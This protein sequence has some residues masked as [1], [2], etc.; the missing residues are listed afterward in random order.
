MTPEGKVK[1]KVNKELGL[2]AHLWSFMPV[3]MGLGKAA[4]DYLLCVRGRFIAIE[5]KA[6]GKKLTT[7][8]L[9]TKAE[10]EAAGAVVFIVDD[11]TSL[12]VAV[13]YIYNIASDE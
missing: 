2:V 3:Q 13:A 1:H 4:L 9:H 12:A 10:M 8:Q 6:K 11:E 7:R 5:T